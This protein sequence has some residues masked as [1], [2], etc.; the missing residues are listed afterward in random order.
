[1]CLCL[2]Q[3]RSCTLPD[4]QVLHTSTQP[5]IIPARRGPS[6][7]S[8]ATNDICTAVHERHRVAFASPLACNGSFP[9]QRLCRQ[10]HSQPSSLR[11]AQKA[12]TC[13]QRTTLGD[14]AQTCIG[15]HLLLA[16]LPSPSRGAA[17][18]HT[19]SH[20]A[21]PPLKEHQAPSTKPAHA[22]TH[23]HWDI[24]TTH[25]HNTFHD[26]YSPTHT[27]HLDIR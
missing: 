23:R 5:A 16:M 25:L 21:S 14:D 6:S 9:F 3:A 17:H 1:M 19:A 22:H 18:K 10:A 20:H 27:L 24:F 13:A 4:Q 2:V 26:T 8:S 11:E 7:N 15:C 12:A